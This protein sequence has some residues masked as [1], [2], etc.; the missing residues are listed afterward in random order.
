MKPL[1]ASNTTRMTYLRMKEFV[2]F[3]FGQKRQTTTGQRTSETVPEP[4]AFLQQCK[5]VLHVG[6]NDGQERDLYAQF[7]LPV[8]WFEALP[9]IFD[10][11]KENLVG[12]PNQVA[13]QALLTDRDGEP[14]TFRIANNGGASSSILNLKYHKDIWPDVCY[15]DEISLTSLSLAS[16]LTSNSIDV[17][18]YDALIMDTQGSELLVL[19]G[20]GTFLDRVK[21]VKTEA[22][23]FEAYENCATVDSIDQFLSGK[24]FG[25]IRKDRF[26]DHPR[27]GG[28]YDVLF[29]RI[30]SA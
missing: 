22:A 24:G 20:S 10:E 25:L 18:S 8:V 4:N 23:D 6:A 11:L 12:Y 15:V 28:Y 17:S 30:S 1:K 27:L 21:F 7:G 14:Y 9:S 19:Q 16:A 26:A 13:V 29:E 3:I 5:G 2:A